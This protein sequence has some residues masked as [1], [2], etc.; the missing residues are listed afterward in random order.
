MYPLSCG[1]E[2][3]EMVYVIASKKRHHFT[4]RE[5]TAGAWMDQ[6]LSPEDREFVLLDCRFAVEFGKLIRG[7]SDEHEDYIT[8]R[9]L[10]FRYV[11]YDTSKDFMRQY[12]R[13]MAAFKQE[14]KKY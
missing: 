4:G 1:P 6:C 10:I 8:K 2:K 5:Q 13:N 11:L 12:M 14:L 3:D 9:S 7:A